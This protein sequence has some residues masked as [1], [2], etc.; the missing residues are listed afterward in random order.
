MRK[1]KWLV[2]LCSC[3]AVAG[4][5]QAY[6]IEYGS[7]ESPDVTTA[8]T[9]N[10]ATG[11]N[12]VP[13][14]GYHAGVVDEQFAQ[15]GPGAIPDAPDGSQWL[16]MDVQD[17]THA[18]VHQ[19]VGDCEAQNQDIV[20]GFYLGTTDV[21]GQADVRLEIASPDLG[22]ATIDYA[23]FDTPASQGSAYHTCTLNT[24]S[25]PTGSKIHLVLKHVSGGW[26]LV[27]DVQVIPEPASL[28]AAMCGLGLLSACRRR[29]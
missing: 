1:F 4:A 15:W 10:E 24:G 2:V 11:W 12:I 20:L 13:G 23:L 17:T 8:I 3:L 25:T 6:V 18:I 9:N 7:F 26:G 28:T 5:A 21:K 19:Y 27:D 14:S 22:W 29:R 16:W